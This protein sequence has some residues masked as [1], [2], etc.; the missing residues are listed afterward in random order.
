V[1][2]RFEAFING[3]ELA[4]GYFELTDAV[5][6]ARRFASDVQQRAQAGQSEVPVDKHLLDA[7]E[8]GMPACAGVALGVDRLL[9]QLQSAG[10][11]AEIMPFSWDRC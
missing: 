11:I 3:M 1:S 4:N 7:L 9:M 8:A 6:Q 2:R 10:S 5:E